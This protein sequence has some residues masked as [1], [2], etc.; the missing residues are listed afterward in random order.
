MI[1]EV[2][3]K[4]SHVFRTQKFDSTILFL[5][6]YS[7]K[8]KQI[9]YIFKCKIYIHLRLFKRS[10]ICNTGILEVTCDAKIGLV[11]LRELCGYIIRPI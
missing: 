11:T 1:V 6:M 9:Q 8:I 2:I 3:L 10:I 4:Y 7:K 5:E